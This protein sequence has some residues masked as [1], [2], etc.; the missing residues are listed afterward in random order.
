MTNI[1]TFERTQQMARTDSTHVFLDVRHLG[2][3]AFARRFPHIDSQCRSFGI[4]PG[5]D[6]IPVHPVAHYMIGGAAVDIDGQTTLDGLL[7]CGEAACTGLHGAN[8]LASNSLVEALVFGKRCGETAGAA[9]KE[10]NDRLIAK[11]VDSV[12]DRSERSFCHPH[13]PITPRR[14]AG[15]VTRGAGPV[16]IW[17]R[18]GPTPAPVP[19][20]ATIIRG[21]SRIRP[22]RAT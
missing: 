3:Q 18:S 1:E 16:S 12:I 11:Q 5:R 17:R 7:A 4:E 21:I 19:V 6:L 14:D 20:C 8:R 9:L 10:V 13:H 22:A 2:G 15:H